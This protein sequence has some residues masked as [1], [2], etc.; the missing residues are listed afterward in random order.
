MTY[1]SC[2]VRPKSGRNSTGEV[3]C[4]FFDKITNID[5]P[6]GFLGFLA[7]YPVSV[8]YFI[9]SYAILSLALSCH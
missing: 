4:T 8:V 6:R 7:K 1:E 9:K 2:Y 5:L 3:I